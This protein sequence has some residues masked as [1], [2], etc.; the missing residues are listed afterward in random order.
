MEWLTSPEFTKLLIKNGSPANFRHSVSADPELQN[1]S[2]VLKVMQSMEKLGQ[3]QLWPRPPIPNIMSIMQ[4]VGEEVHDAIWG[5]VT[6]RQ[7]LQRAESRIV[8][9][10]DKNKQEN[11]ITE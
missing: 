10:F 11:I 4:I 3:L 8:P 5:G 7:A 9:L 2:P 6:T 1:A